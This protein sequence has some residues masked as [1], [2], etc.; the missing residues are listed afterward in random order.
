MIQ[1]RPAAE[2]GH[3]SHG[4]LESRH[5]FSFG[6]YHDPSQMGFRALRV[7]N[8]DRVQPGR[9]FGEHGHRDMEI[10]SWVL[11]GAL[12]HRDSLGH[13]SVIRPGELQRMSAGTGVLH[14]ELNASRDEEVHFLQIWVLPERVGLP[15]SYEQRPF[16]EVERRD[17]LRLV[18]AREP[19][20]GAVRIHQDA[21]LYAALL[22]ADKSLRHVLAK[23][24]HAWLQ[25]ARGAVDL[26][27]LRL[28]AGDGA[29][30]W[31]EPCLSIRADEPAELLLFDLA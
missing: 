31:D 15:P 25:V 5:T 23:G 16:P 29:A 21:E 27:D 24:R 18:A 1:V 10:L 11:A 12:A 7:I 30:V 17:R 6:G 22:G 8:E 26:G 2:R 3:S 19:R 28:A 9:G 20:D 4:W 14:S 13:G